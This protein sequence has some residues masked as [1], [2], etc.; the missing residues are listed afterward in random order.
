MPYKNKN[1]QRKYQREW[2]A[3]SRAIYLN[4]KVCALCGSDSNLNV[5]HVDPSEKI[6]HK[7]WSWSE[8]RKTKELAKCVVLCQPCHTKEHRPVTLKLAREIRRLY[9]ET[10]TSHRKL[11]RQLGLSRNVVWRILANKYWPEDNIA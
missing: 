11:A 10:T 2:M 7:V 8:A 3:A 5:H 1:E 9:K 6:D 4:D